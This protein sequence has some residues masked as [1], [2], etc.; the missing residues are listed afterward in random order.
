MAPPL[1]LYTYGMQRATVGE[2]LR[3]FHAAG[4]K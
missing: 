1:T 3:D 2:H 4:V